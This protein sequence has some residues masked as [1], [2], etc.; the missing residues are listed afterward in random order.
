MWDGL[1][2]WLLE[3]WESFV[4]FMSDLGITILD[5]LLDAIAG[6]LEA[7]PIPDF[8]QGHTI[9]D[10]LNSVDPAVLYFLHQSGIGVALAIIGSAT[11]FRMLRKLLT[12][13]NW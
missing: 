2:A 5:G 12:L 1:V 9:A 11:L 3:L 10:Y 13:G 4:A 6:V 8:L 7:L